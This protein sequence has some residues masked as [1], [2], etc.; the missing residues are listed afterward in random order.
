M[1]PTKIIFGRGTL[2]QLGPE[3]KRWGEKALLVTGKSA[4]RKSGILEKIDINTDALFL[5][6]RRKTK[7]FRPYGTRKEIN[8]L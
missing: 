5:I 3:V 1:Y 8:L 2:E 6:L 7:C 4:I